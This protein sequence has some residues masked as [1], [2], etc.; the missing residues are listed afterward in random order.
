M[1]NNN[2]GLDAVCLP[3]NRLVLAC[4]PVGS[5]W[6]AR[7]PLSLFVSESGGQTWKRELDLAAGP[8]EYSYPAV[9]S[10]GDRKRPGNRLAGTDEC[11]PRYHPHW[12]PKP[13]ALRRP[14]TCPPCIG[15]ARTALKPTLRAVSL[16]GDLRGSLPAG[17][18]PSPARFEVSLPRRPHHGERQGVL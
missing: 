6:G 1:P 14:M 5:D 8:G 2:S 12:Q 15:S 3:D 13:P 16:R 9:I 7:T 11:H 18:A 4:N 17:L 10:A